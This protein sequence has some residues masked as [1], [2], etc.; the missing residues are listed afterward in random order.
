MGLT[1]SWI[2]IAYIMFNCQSVIDS[3][4]KRYLS[5]IS[6]SIVQFVTDFQV[7]PTELKVQSFICLSGMDSIF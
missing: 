2:P 1:V 7:G 6:Q 4:I 3:T 5:N